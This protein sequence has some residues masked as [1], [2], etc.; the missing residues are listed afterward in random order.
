[1][2]AGE[3]YVRDFVSFQ[4]DFKISFHFPLPPSCAAPFPMFSCRPSSAFFARRRHSDFGT[5][6]FSR[7]SQIT[8]VIL[9]LL[10]FPLLS[11]SLLF[12]PR[13]PSAPSSHVSVVGRS[14]VQGSP[15]GLYGLPSRGR[16]SRGPRVLAPHMT[17]PG[18][19]CFHV[20]L[21][22]RR[23]ALTR[24]LGRCFFG[25]QFPPL[26]NNSRPNEVGAAG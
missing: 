4:V 18:T 8:T 13:S 24:R 9:F 5:V 7:T 11:S 20:M 23:G 12:G 19:A 26:A 2:S 25:F 14:R 15:C 21:S 22:G 1:M 10:S 16:T 17:A 6:Y 3:M